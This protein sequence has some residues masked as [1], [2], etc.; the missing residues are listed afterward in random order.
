MVESTWAPEKNE[1]VD[2]GSGPI[3]NT[4]F[5]ARVILFV[6]LQEEWAVELAEGKQSL[7]L[8]SLLLCIFII[9]TKNEW[10]SVFG[11]GKFVSLCV[12]IFGAD[13][14]E[15]FWMAAIQLQ[16]RAAF[17][18]TQIHPTCEWEWVAVGGERREARN[19]E[20]SVT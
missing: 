9:I 11:V 14:I 8:S 12:V 2:L 19:D 15:H 13:R 17:S 1:P 10:M 6:S 5:W 16:W 4:F 7:V 18:F 20:S 3:E